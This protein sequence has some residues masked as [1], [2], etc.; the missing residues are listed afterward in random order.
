LVGLLCDF[1]CF[2]LFLF[3]CKFS[4]KN[5]TPGSKSWLISLELLLG[6]FLYKISFVIAPWENIWGEKEK[7]SKTEVLYY[8][9]KGHEMIK[10]KNGTL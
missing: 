4:K 7:L 9:T 2:L 1:P 6:F 10:V 5:P 3:A 8:N